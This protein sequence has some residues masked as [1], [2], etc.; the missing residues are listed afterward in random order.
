MK[1]LIVNAF[2]ATII[3]FFPSPQSKGLEYLRTLKQML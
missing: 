3:F 1:I 2:M